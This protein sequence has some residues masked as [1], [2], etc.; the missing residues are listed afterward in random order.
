M[1]QKIKDLIQKL[2]NDNDN[3]SIKLNNNKG[4]DYD[5]RKYITIKYNHNLEIIRDLEII[6]N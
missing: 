1:E 2:S 3:A 6:L 5:M 4:L